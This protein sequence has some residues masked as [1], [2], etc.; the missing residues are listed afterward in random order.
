MRIR[1][2]SLVHKLLQESRVSILQKARFQKIIVNGLVMINS[3]FIYDELEPEYRAI[4][5]SSKSIWT[6]ESACIRVKFDSNFFSELL[7]YYKNNTDG[8]F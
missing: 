2:G 5:T 6:E 8:L 4:F 1:R 3:S 7:G